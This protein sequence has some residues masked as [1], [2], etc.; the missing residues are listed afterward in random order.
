MPIEY[1]VISAWGRTITYIEEF[2]DKISP[3]KSAN[4]IEGSKIK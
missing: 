4:K 1:S 2:L 3:L